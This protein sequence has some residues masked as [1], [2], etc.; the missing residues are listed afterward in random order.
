LRKRFFKTGRD[1][2]ARAGGCRLS[3]SV[4]KSLSTM[5]P[6]IR[7]A[8]GPAQ[9]EAGDWATPT[10]QAANSTNATATAIKSL[11]TRSI[12]TSLQQ[13][14]SAHRRQRAALCSYFSPIDILNCL[15]TRQAILRK[16]FWSAFLMWDVPPETA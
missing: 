16:E 2:P 5:E 9:E 10:T 1:L 12:K 8:L 13:R 4:T 3:W 15:E 7:P 6:T 11:P 14:I